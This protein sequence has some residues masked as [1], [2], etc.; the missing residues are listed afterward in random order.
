MSNPSGLRTVAVLAGIAAC[1]LLAGCE[2]KGPCAAYDRTA[3]AV[4]GGAK[5]TYCLSRNGLAQGP[6]KCVLENGLGAVTGRYKDGARQGTWVFMGPSS[7]V[8]RRENWRDDRML[9]KEELDPQL[10]PLP[11]EITRLDCDGHLIRRAP[12]QP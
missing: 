3:E 7:E 12:A 2:R 6:Y 8:I 10:P 11:E 4:K 1:A 9:G 5:I